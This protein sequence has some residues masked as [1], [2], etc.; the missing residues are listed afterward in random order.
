MQLCVVHMYSIIDDKGEEVV[1]SFTSPQEVERAMR[2]PL[3]LLVS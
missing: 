3:R 2:S 1:T